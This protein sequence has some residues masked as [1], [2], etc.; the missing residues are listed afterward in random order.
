MQI[1]LSRRREKG[2]HEKIYR[3][4]EREGSKGEKRLSILDTMRGWRSCIF[5]FHSHPSSLSL[6]S[7]YRLISMLFSQLQ[8]FLQHVSFFFHF[9]LVSRLLSDLFGRLHK[10]LN[11]VKEEPWAWRTFFLSLSFIFSVTSHNL[12]EVGAHEK[13]ERRWIDLQRKNSNKSQ[14]ILVFFP[15]FYSRSPKLHRVLSPFILSLFFSLSFSFSF[16]SHR[17]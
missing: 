7:F 6:S 9:S 10:N 5:F 17:L 15:F 8:T 4:E 14:C 12:K 13:V 3:H 16:H 1:I 11:K 2:I